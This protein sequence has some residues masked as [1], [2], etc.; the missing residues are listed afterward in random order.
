MA[1]VSGAGLLVAPSGIYCTEQY[2]RK[3]SRKY[4]RMEQM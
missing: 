2:S 4:S 3:Y 1:D